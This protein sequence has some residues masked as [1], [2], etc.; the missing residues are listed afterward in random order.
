M[1]EKSP[2]R[3]VWNTTCLGNEE[4][5]KRGKLVKE[6]W[7]EE[8]RGK[9]VNTRSSSFKGDG[10]MSSQIQWLI[11]RQWWR[12]E[13]RST[14]EE[15]VYLCTLCELNFSQIVFLFAS[16][17]FWHL[18]YCRLSITQQWAKLILNI[19]SIIIKTLE[20][21]LTGVEWEYLLPKVC[22]FLNVCNSAQWRT[23]CFSLY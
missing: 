21:C 7:N 11:S 2:W 17:W 23:Y 9:K 5:E 22:M 12:V 20:C 14:E 4:T 1:E 13:W 6:T 19:L 10:L 16:G 3:T 15:C 8:M 18:M